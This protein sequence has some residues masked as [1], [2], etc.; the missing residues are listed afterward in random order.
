MCNLE[1]EM[2]IFVFTTGPSRYKEEKIFVLEE[3]T[4]M[5]PRFRKKK[6]VVS[7]AKELSTYTQKHS[8]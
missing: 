7:S 3:F 2:K 5:R 1:K 6:K 8:Y 4:H